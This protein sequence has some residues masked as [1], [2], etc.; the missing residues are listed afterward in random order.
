[1]ERLENRQLL[2]VS[3]GTGTAYPGLRAVH[4]AVADMNGDSKPDIVA[5]GT[6]PD[7][8]LPAVAVF[9]NK[10]DGTFGPA[11]T[12]AFAPPSADAVT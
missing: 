7:G 2:S 6:T 5:I 10:G 1:M 4:V 12:L 8:S 3:F 11:V 9:P